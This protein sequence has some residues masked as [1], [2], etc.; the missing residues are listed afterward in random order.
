[1]SIGELAKQTG[2]SVAAIRFYEERGLLPHPVRQPNNRRSYGPEF[3]VALSLVGGCRRSGMDLHTIK[4]LQVSLQ[5]KGDVCQNSSAV[6]RDA[7]KGLTAKISELQ[8][9]RRALS[10]VAST[11]GPAMC[12]E[13]LN[14]CVVAEGMCSLGHD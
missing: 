13:Q 8:A 5:G 11:C 10:R 9:A 1:M 12:G 14:S 6:L 2:V 4:K 7:I 3:V